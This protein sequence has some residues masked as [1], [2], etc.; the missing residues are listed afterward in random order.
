MAL[1]AEGE[2]ALV[3][4]LTTEFQVTETQARNA[5]NVA[6]MG[7]ACGGEAPLDVAG[8]KFEQAGD[9]LLV[10][11]DHLMIC[12][13]DFEAGA[14]PRKVVSFAQ[15]EPVDDEDGW[16]GFDRYMEMQRRWLP[17]LPTAA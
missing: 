8:L 17:Q 11:E 13:L 4:R 10:Y 7:L 1:Y 9:A 12:T 6:W 2:I 5:M 3:T 16:D 15:V 14:L